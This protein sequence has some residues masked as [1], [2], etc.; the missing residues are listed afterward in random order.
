MA[1]HK[2]D[3]NS[4][5][6]WPHPMD[7]RTFQVLAAGWLLAGCSATNEMQSKCRRISYPSLSPYRLPSLSRGDQCFCFAAAL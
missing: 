6:G 2:T 3:F 7:P 1:E 4:T 5:G